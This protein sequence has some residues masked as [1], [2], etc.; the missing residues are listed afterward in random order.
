MIR[1]GITYR[2]KQRVTEAGIFPG[3]FIGPSWKMKHRGYERTKNECCIFC[4]AIDHHCILINTSRFKYQ[5]E[6]RCYV[7]KKKAVSVYLDNET[8]LALYRLREDIRKKNAETGMALPTP[9][10][11][12]LARSLLRQSLG[13]KADKKDLPH[14]G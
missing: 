5:S 13:I 2:F 12:W 6:T 1:T 9:T 3:F 8:A 11:G 4:N 10:V 7:N 14:E